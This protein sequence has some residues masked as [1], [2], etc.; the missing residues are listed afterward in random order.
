MTPDDS[1]P[2]RIRSLMQAFAVQ[3][4]EFADQAGII[5]QTL[6]SILTGRTRPGA[7]TLQSVK[8]RWPQV[9]LNW[10]LTGLGEMFVSAGPIAA[11][12]VQEAL[13]QAVIARAE[14]HM[15]QQ[16]VQ[17][18]GAMIA[19]LQ[20]ELERIRKQSGDSGQPS[21]YV[22]THPHNRPV[23]GFKLAISR[24]VRGVRSEA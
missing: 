13:S 4:S 11:L 8:T 7:E 19:T 16:Q 23:V 21:A 20:R 15:Y 22:P 18:Q 5:R 9:D 2:A 17:S 24:R 10:L 12:D 6:S 3:Q 1:I 14:S